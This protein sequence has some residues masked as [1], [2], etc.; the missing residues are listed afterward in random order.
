[1]K[2]TLDERPSANGLRNGRGA[3]REAEI[4]PR[5][6]VLLLICFGLNAV[7][8]LGLWLWPSHD[9]RIFHNWTIPPLLILFG[10]MWKGH[11]AAG[12]RLRKNRASGLMAVGVVV[13][14]VVTGWVLFYPPSEEM[15]RYAS[16]WH[17]WL[18]IGLI[19]VLVLHSVLGWRSR[20]KM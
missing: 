3:S 20:E 16:S 8:G 14:V 5:M 19:L 15:Q 1:M 11:M 9:W 10:V 12:W 18:G 4:L 6:L 7:S 13:A 17:T 2:E